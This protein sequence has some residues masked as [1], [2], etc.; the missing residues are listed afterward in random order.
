MSWD[1][2][3]LQRFFY[4]EFV[5]FL[6]AHERKKKGWVIWPKMFPLRFIHAI[7]YLILWF[8]LILSLPAFE[9]PKTQKE[10]KMSNYVGGETSFLISFH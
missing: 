3:K 5:D 9:R 10:E 7:R 1:I 6:R 2:P 8:A 4:I